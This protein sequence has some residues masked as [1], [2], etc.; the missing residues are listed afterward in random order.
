MKVLVAIIS[1][2]LLCSSAYSQ[3]TRALEQ[4][5]SNPNRPA[6]DKTRDANR[7][8]PEILQ[9]MG[10]KEG[11]TALDVIAMGGWY[12]EILSYAVG[13]SG[14]VYMQNNPIAVTENSTDERAERMSRLSNVENF[15]G[16][17]SD[18]PPNSIDFAITALNFHD[19]HNRSVV[20]I[21][22]ML[23]SI[24]EVLRPGGILT[25]IDHEGTE[26]A[27]NTTLHRIAFEDAVKTSLKAG[28]VLI[29]TS[30]LL[31]NAE[32]DHTLSPFDPS[33]ERRTDRFVLKLAKPR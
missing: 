9:F 30:D 3:N 24:L 5:L 23:K 21:D 8:A 19:V 10:V 2:G 16:P 6:Q 7:K 17:V 15:I 29:G 25:V 33:L 14:K 13:Q 11:D 20:D 26:G 31:E 28:F 32:D 4:A 1:L 22:A 18:I 12:S 27:D